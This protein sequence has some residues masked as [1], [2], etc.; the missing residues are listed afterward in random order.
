MDEKA[1]KT[2]M[3]VDYTQVSEDMAKIFKSLGN[4][5]TDE[6]KAKLAE[7]IIKSHTDVVV[8]QI[9]GYNAVAEEVAK[10]NSKQMEYDRL[11]KLKDIEAESEKRKVQGEMVGEVLK[12]A[13]GLFGVCVNA[14]MGRRALDAKVSLQKSLIG[15]FCKVMSLEKDGDWQSESRT[16]TAAMN[17]GV[18]G[19]VRHI[20][21]D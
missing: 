4:G 12:T 5:L 16:G 6:A 21:E 7:T 1:A 17:A 20:M 2:E 19:V 13:V 11:E 15:G 8:E 14:A 9:K 3:G 10:R 18:S